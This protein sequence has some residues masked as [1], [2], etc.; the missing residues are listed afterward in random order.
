MTTEPQ[1][2][3][4]LIDGDNAQPSLLEHVLVEAAKYGAVNDEADLIWQ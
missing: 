3:A 1:P 2:L 4:M